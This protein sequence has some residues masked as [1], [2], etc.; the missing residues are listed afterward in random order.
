MTKLS[1]NDNGILNEILKRLDMLIWMHS[2][3]LNAIKDVNTNKKVLKSID[4]ITLI[5]M[6]PDLRKT[7]MAMMEL[8]TATVEEVSIKTGRS[9]S[10]EAYCL[11]H[12]CKD[13]YLVKK[14]GERIIFSVN[15]YTADYQYF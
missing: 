9:V 8:E 4:A 14:N 15:D 5:E 3:I 12:L 2:E 1:E 6:P 13:G 11:E 10:I 7:M